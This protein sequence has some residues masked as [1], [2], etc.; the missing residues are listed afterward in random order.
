VLTTFEAFAARAHVT[1]LAWGARTGGTVEKTDAGPRF[2]KFV[3][4]IDMEVTDVERAR[5]VVEE[6]RK[7]CLVSNALNIPVEI[8]AKI[9]EPVRK[10]G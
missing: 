4:E 3:V 9:H 1:V 10:A 6:T 7:H 8:D 5:A 2:T